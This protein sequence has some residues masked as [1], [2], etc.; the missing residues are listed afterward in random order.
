MIRTRSFEKI[1]QILIAQMTE[2]QTRNIRIQF[3]SCF[4]I[5]DIRHTLLQMVPPNGIDLSPQ[6]WVI[7]RA[8][9]MPQNVLALVPLSHF[10]LVLQ[11][12]THFFPNLANGSANEFRALQQTRLRLHIVTALAKMASSLFVTDTRQQIEERRM[13]K[14]VGVPHQKNL[15]GQLAVRLVAHPFLQV[16]PFHGHDSQAILPQS[17]VP[18]EEAHYLTGAFVLGPVGGEIVPVLFVALIGPVVAIAHAFLGRE[19]FGERALQTPGALSVRVDALGRPPGGRRRT[20]GRRDLLRR[21]APVVLDLEVG[22]AQEEDYHYRVQFFRGRDV[23][24]RSTVTVAGVYVGSSVQQRRSR[25]LVRL[26]DGQM[27]GFELFGHAGVHVGSVGNENGYSSKISVPRGVVQGGRC[28]ARMHSA[29]DSH[30]LLQ[31]VVEE[32]DVGCGR[33]VE[34]GLAVEERDAGVGT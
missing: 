29:I 10:Q 19:T 13:A 27:Q 4:L 1:A 15:L 32:L 18:L 9:K 34:D 14:A 30:V 26:E 2:Y 17:R 7:T 24:R 33:E 23:E 12:K 11:M 21:L 20:H 6:Q 31:D 8:R 25:F 28:G 16:P 3:D 22:I 5:N